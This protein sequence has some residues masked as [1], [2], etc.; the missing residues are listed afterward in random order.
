MIT[1]ASQSSCNPLTN[2]CIV[3]IWDCNSNCVINKCPWPGMV[4]IDEDPWVEGEGDQ[5]IYTLNSG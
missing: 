2:S 5:I 3:P 1:A 4:T